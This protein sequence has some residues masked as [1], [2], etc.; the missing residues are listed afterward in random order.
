M[1]YIE[2]LFDKTLEFTLRSKDKFTDKERK[3]RGLYNLLD[4]TI[5]LNAESLG[6]KIRDEQTGKLFSLADI[7][8]ELSKKGYSYSKITEKIEASNDSLLKKSLWTMKHCIAHEL[9]HCN[10][11]AYSKLNYWKSALN[12]KEFKTVMD[13][14]QMKAACDNFFPSD[15]HKTNSLEFVAETF[16]QKVLG[17]QTPKIIENFYK[18]YGGVEI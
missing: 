18:K 10:H 11:Y 3:Y 8:N 12:Q 7:F 16:A 5:Y 9:G 13:N 4:N 2:R 1:N 17:K 15:Y 6:N 14:R